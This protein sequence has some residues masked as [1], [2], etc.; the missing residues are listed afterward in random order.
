MGWLT[1][2]SEVQF[3][4]IM[5]IY[6]GVQADIVLEKKPRVLHLVVNRK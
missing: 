1:Y 2:S 5:V 6:G 3:I 4:I